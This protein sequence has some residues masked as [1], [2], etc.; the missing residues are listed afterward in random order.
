MHKLD[1]REIV[2]ANAAAGKYFFERKT[3]KFFGDYVSNWDAFEVNGRRFIRNARH[4]R[5]PGIFEHCTIRGQWREV[6]AEGDIS[7][8]IKDAHGLTPKAFATWLGASGAGR[9]D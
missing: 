4:K 9:F 2:A 5:G 3:L 8:P 1:I 7:M 6:H